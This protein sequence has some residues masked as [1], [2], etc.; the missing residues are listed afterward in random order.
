MITNNI[1]IKTYW[2]TRDKPRDLDDEPE[3]R[4]AQYEIGV[5][6][7]K[8]GKKIWIELIV[9]INDNEKRKFYS[10]LEF[11]AGSKFAEDLKEFL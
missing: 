3:L 10:H 6:D 2:K 1:P 7:S 11:P 8:Y 9:G 5:R 4:T